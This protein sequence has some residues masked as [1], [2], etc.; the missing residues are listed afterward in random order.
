[1]LTDTNP[2]ARKVPLPAA[3]RGRVHGD[4]AR[5]RHPPWH[6]D[7]RATAPATFS[8]SFLYSLLVCSI[9]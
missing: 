9:S 8:S 6:V 5:L 7:S 4:G 2:A 1:M 3:L